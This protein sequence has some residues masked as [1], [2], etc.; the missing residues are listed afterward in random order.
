M[1]NGSD[2]ATEEAAGHRAVPHTADLRV[3]A[4]APTRE[5]CIAEAVLG[6]VE[7][8]VDI[9]SAHPE[10]TQRCRVEANS[11]EDL[12]VAVLDEL[13]YTLDTTGRIPVDVELDTLDSGL[14]VRFATIDAAHL[15]Q[16]GA[17]PKA[18]SL[19][20]LYLA[21]GPRGWSCSVTLDV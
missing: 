7:A 13:I 4:W 9:A 14:D 3:E 1:S 11:D 2:Q 19:H 16:V 20:D 15:P 18:V 10:S 8:F 12:L 21:A 5:G 17:V 6:T